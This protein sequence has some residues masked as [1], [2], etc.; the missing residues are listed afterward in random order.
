MTEN[1]EQYSKII[2]IEETGNSI[3]ETINN[4]EN[5][6][7]EGLYHFEGLSADDYFDN[8]VEAIHSECELAKEE[9][10]NVIIVFDNTEFFV[11][12]V[13]LNKLRD[14]G[15]KIIVV[16]RDPWDGIAFDKKIE[17]NRIGNKDDE[18]SLFLSYMDVSGLD[19]TES[20]AVD[21]I[22][23]HYDGH[24]LLLELIAKAMNSSGNFLVRC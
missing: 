3:R 11:E 1:E 8:K 10:K 19:K 16:S 20:E 6:K 14:A 4:D 21:K 5:L 24:P 7:I 17:I 18:L 23:E 22:I 13:Y 12:L 9:K 15:C 2:Y